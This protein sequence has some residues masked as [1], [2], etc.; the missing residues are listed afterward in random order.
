MWLETLTGLGEESREAVHE[1]LAVD[2]E[3]LHSKINGAVFRH[4]RLET[5]TLA[6]LRARAEASR[7]TTGVLSIAECVADVQALHRDPANAGALFQV[8]SQFNLLEMISPDVTPEDGVER[9]DKDPTQGPAC[10]VAAGAGTIYRNYFAPVAGAVGQTRNNQ[11][12][13]LRDLGDALGNTGERLWRMQNGYALASKEGLRE[14]AERLR[15]CDDRELDALRAR[16]RIGV[17]WDTEVTI[18]PSR[19]VVTQAYCAALPI[20]YSSLGP[21][22]WEPFARLVL[23]ATYEATLCC[24]VL[25]AASSG[26]H[27]VYLTKIGGGVFANDM[28]WICD[29][30]DRAARRHRS[31]GL[32]VRIVSYGRPDPRIEPLLC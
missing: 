3:R 13:C 11:I 20:G 7:R 10:A 14:I 22:D 28:Q 16:L 1:N 18:A 17:Q 21:G 29:A 8:A 23:E 24:G 2:G 12:D 9:Y 32:D 6:D 15:Q 26:N 4:G 31:A 5:P 27:S 30:I 19:H 25:N